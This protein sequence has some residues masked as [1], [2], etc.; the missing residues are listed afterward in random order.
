MKLE[1]YGP[2][3][4]WGVMFAMGAAIKVVAFDSDSLFFDVGPDAAL[5]A[6]GILFSLAVSEQ[7][8]TGAR[9]VHTVTKK[10]TGAG[11]EVDYAVFINDD[12]GFKPKLLYLFVA[13]IAI[14]IF[15]LLVSGVAQEDYSGASRYTV[16][17]LVYALLGLALAF[18]SVM[19]ALRAL[20]EATK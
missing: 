6:V 12:P 14:W 4:V 20:L 11:V 9:L 3:L 8:H 15:V 2:L 5:W 7:S 17:I 18:T 16:R 13:G 10:P 19:L 1:T